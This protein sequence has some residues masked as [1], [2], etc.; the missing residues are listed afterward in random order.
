LRS[1]VFLSP[2]T[3]ETVSAIVAGYGGSIDSVPD[4]RR[5]LTAIASTDSDCLVIDPSLITATIAETI[6]VTLS[7]YPRPVVASSAITAV[8]MDSAVILAERTQ[9]RFIFRGVPAEHSLL[10]RALLLT[11]DAR[12][13]AALL[14]GI[15]AQMARLTSVIR[16]RLR[17]VLLTVND[18]LKFPRFD[19][20]KFPTAGACS[21]LSS[22]PAS[23]VSWGGDEGLAD[24]PSLPLFS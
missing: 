12:L 1:I 22:Y 17:D 7:K 10:E 11:P 18:R 16:D 24:E 8:A 5:L 14:S 21:V 6:V 3:L 9:A 23:L 20:L 4:A 19:L 2:D 15:D 13:S